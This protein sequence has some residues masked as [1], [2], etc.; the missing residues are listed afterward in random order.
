LSPSPSDPQ[1]SPTVKATPARRGRARKK[2]N[3]AEDESS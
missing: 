2:V 3:Y 1:A